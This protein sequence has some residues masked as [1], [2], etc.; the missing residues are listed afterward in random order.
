MALALVYNLEIIHLKIK[1]R[2]EVLTKG[3][4]FGGK[5]ALHI[6]FNLSQKGI[7]FLGPAFNLMVSPD[8]ANAN[9]SYDLNYFGYSIEAGAR[10]PF[11]S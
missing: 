1:D 4:G 8:G 10:L 3:I 2:E 5:T 9:S 7:I 6:E 11:E